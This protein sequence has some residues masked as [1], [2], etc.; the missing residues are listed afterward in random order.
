M[1]RREVNLGLA[2]GS[3]VFEWQ[4]V[5]GLGSSDGS[6]QSGASLFNTGLVSFQADLVGRNA[7][8]LEETVISRG[9]LSSVTEASHPEFFHSGSNFYKRQQTQTQLTAFTVE[10]LNKFVL[11]GDYLSSEGQYLKVKV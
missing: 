11:K 10:E 4:A 2:L 5:D 9:S 8:T 3:L 1:D 6:D 7:E